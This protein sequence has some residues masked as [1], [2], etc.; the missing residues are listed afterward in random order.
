MESLRKEL[1]EDCKKIAPEIQSLSAKVSSLMSG[2][3]ETY[4]EVVDLKYRQG[5]ERI[6]A[7]HQVY[8]D[9]VSTSLDHWVLRFHSFASELETEYRLSTDSEKVRERERERREN[10]LICVFS[11]FTHI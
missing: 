5:I 8:S 11:R 10:R 7:S 3:A 6:E 9:G 4:T 1:K 2:I